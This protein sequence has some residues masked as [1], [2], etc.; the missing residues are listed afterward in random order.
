VSGELSGVFIATVKDVKLDEQ[1]RIGIEIPSKNASYQARVASATAGKDRGMVFL[2]EK[3]DQVVVAFI[4]GREAEPVVIGSLWSSVAKPPSA[5]PDGNNDVKLIKTRSGHLIR[6]T[7]KQ[8]EEKIEIID[9]TE[10]LRF[11]LD[12]G[13]QCIAIDATDGK[14]VLSAKRIAIEAAQELELRS[15]ESTV[16]IAAK[17]NTT[18]SGQ[19]VELNP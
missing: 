11:L 8:D 1:G 10:K 19:I 3:N 4:N 5:D 12:S 6:L 18:I 13:N 17:G 9:R 16:T 15:A 14:I 2:P 7:D